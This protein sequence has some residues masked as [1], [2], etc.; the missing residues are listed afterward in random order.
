M[1]ILCHK[2]NDLVHHRPV[3]IN[4]MAATRRWP[5][6]QWQIS[7]AQTVVVGQ[8]KTEANGWCMCVC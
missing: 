7:E 8:T 6:V 4:R 1:Y 2:K 5:S 3:D